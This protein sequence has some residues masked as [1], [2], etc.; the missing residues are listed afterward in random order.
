[1]KREFLLGIILLSLP[2]ITPN[3]VVKS[4]WLP[5]D[6][7]WALIICGFPST[8]ANPEGMQEDPWYM[9][10]VLTQHYS[11]KEVRLIDSFS[12]E[13]KDKDG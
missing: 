4:A 11:F 6:D 12:F 13:D 2:L 7:C 1:M 5:L 3:A 8:T 9:K 10:N